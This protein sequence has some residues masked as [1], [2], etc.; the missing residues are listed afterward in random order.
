MS[1][2]PL[3]SGIRERLVGAAPIFFERFALPREHRHAGFRD[4]GRGVILG[5]E[6]IAARPAHDRAELDQRFDQHRG[7]DRHVQ[8]TGDAH[9]LQRL[10]SART[11]RGSPSGPA[12]PFPRWR[13]LCG[14]NRPG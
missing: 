14:P 9:A 13:F 8:R 5:G 1:C 4:G 7:L 2:G 11:S 3:P 10:C 6:N 12:F